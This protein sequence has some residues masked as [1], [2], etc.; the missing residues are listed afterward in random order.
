MSK[1]QWFRA[2]THGNFYSG[3]D[4]RLILAELLNVNG[5]DSGNDWGGKERKPFFDIT[6]EWI[7]NNWDTLAKTALRQVGLNVIN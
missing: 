7:Y 4:R 2:Y 5:I 1:P 6:I 3:E